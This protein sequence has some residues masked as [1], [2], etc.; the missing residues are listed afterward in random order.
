MKKDLKD[1]ETIETTE[2]EETIET[3]TT[4]AET[5]DLEGMTKNKSKITV[6]YSRNGSFCE[7]TKGAVFSWFLSFIDKYILLFKTNCGIL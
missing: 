6:K 4:E 2:A 7:F 1:Q 5:A 3:E